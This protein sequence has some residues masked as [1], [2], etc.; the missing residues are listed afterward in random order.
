MR[1][2]LSEITSRVTDIFAE[3]LLLPSGA[4]GGELGLWGRG[5]PERLGGHVGRRDAVVHQR[6]VPHWVKCVLQGFG[7]E[8]VG[9]W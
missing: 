7:A 9:L 8:L 4:V 5:L 2:R 3:R 6:L 1:R